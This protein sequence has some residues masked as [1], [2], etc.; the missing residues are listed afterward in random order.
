MELSSLLSNP[1]LH[2]Y[3]KSPLFSDLRDSF[4]I[5]LGLLLPQLD[6][7]GIQGISR[8]EGPADYPQRVRPAQ[9]KHKVILK[10]NIQLICILE[11]NPVEISAFYQFIIFF[12]ISSVYHSGTKVYF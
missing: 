2:L 9:V 8:P 6:G 1:R 10:T 11:R 4:Q 5:T 12:F 3:L 7:G